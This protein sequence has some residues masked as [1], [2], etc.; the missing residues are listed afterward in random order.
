MR[1]SFSIFFD[2]HNNHRVGGRVVFFKWHPGMTYTW[3][4]TETFS[5]RL[6]FEEIPS[7]NRMLFFQATTYLV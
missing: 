4:I 7:F 3:Q 2:K 5:G 1:L 6:R